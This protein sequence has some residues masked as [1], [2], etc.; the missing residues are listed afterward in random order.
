MN[1]LRLLILGLLAT[2]LTSCSLEDERDECCGVTLH[3][4]YMEKGQDVFKDNIHEMRH[5]LFDGEGIY[6]REILT[7]GTTNQVFLENI[8]NG[9]YTMITVANSTPANTALTNLKANVSRLNEFQLS[10]VDGSTRTSE[11]GYYD[12]TDELFY[13]SAQ[14]EVTPSERDFY[15]EDLSNIHCHLHVYLYWHKLPD[16]RGNFTMRLYD[17]PANFSL[18]PDNM[19]RV[20]SATDDDSLTPNAINSVLLFPKKMNRI[21][22]SQI[23]VMP[24]NFRLMGEFVTHRWTDEQIPVLQVFNGDQI[25]TRP[26]PL[27]E[28]FAS[29]KIHPNNDT[30]QDYWIEIEVYPDGTSYISR[31]FGARVNDW[32]DGGTVSG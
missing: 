20:K 10:Q 32:I 23:E 25:V 24:Y 17:V 15:F 26:I 21:V 11:D 30:V 1:R 16:Y 12:N 14:F 31:Y 9:K 5:F 8:Y 7:S 22:D 27:G 3:F 13:N 6:Q 4:R 29:W 19:M 2:L 18:S 28:V